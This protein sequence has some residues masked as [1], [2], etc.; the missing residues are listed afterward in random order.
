MSRNGARRRWQELIAEQS[1][2]DL[3]IAAFCR[4]NDV[5]QASFYR[6]RRRLGES[7]A[8][9]E[10]FVPVSIIDGAVVSVQLP[11]GAVV[12]VPA[13]DDRSLSQIITLLMVDQE[14][15]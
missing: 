5:S 9:H 1:R 3:S 2:S 8:A 15:A 12:R 10:P 7:V 4:E 11:C 13:G 6:W 14:Q